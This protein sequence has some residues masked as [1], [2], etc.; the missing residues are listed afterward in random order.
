MDLVIVVK[1]VLI[2]IGIEENVKP[3]GEKNGG[4]D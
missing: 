2:I 3:P 4:L 1:P